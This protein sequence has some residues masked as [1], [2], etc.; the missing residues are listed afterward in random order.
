MDNVSSTP[1]IVED[2]D[3]IIRM[4]SINNPYHATDED[5]IQI[6]LDAH[7]VMAFLW[8]PMKHGLIIFTSTLRIDPYL[9]VAR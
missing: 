7:H 3:K 9:K 6:F 1:I 5:D 4:K 8:F 2:E